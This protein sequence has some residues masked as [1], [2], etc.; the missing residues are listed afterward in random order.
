MLSQLSKE[1]LIYCLCFSVAKAKQKN[2][3]VQLLENKQTNQVLHMFNYQSI[4]SRNVHQKAVMSQ[5]VQNL[6]F[7]KI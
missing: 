3:C 4:S 5:K 7:P 1:E 6:H 2:L